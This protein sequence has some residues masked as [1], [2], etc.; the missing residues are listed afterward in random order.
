MILTVR[1]REKQNAESRKEQRVTGSNRKK[2]PEKRET[3]KKV[4][5]Y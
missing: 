5:V 3:E 4:E 1:N 2:S